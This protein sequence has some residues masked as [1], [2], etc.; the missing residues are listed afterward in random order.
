MIQESSGALL[1]PNPQAEAWLEAGLKEVAGAVAALCADART[2]DP[3]RDEYGHARSRAY[4]DA[5]ALLK[6]GARVGHTIAELRGSKFEHN[7]N[8]RRG[9]AAS[10]EAP[11]YPTGPGFGFQGR[12][13]L[14]D[15]RVCIMAPN[16]RWRLVE[17]EEPPTPV[18]EGSNGNSAR[19]TAV[20]PVANNEDEDEDDNEGCLQYQ[21]HYYDPEIRFADGTHFVRGLG[22]RHIPPDWD[23][24]AWRRAHGR[25]GE[26][27][28]TPV[29]E[30][31][32]G[33]FA[34]SDGADL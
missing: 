33:N 27:T 5:V 31:S 4:T 24:E 17:D 23:E 16:N 1:A 3:A 13:R 6:A 10:P 12:I 7:I 18:S 29:S 34:K 21:G 14:T 8:V 11:K 32:N 25:G 15:G 19:A 30:G 22:R 2:I 20:E 9:E 28:P 26:G